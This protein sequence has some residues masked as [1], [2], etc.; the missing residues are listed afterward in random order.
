MK[1]YLT[2]QNRVTTDF[3]LLEANEKYI[4]KS[5]GKVGKS[6]I[7]KS[8]SNAGS[9]DN[10]IE[11]IKKET[12]EL[13][14]K[15]FSISQLPQDLTSSDIVFDKAKWHINDEFPKDLD[16]YQSYIHT[17]LYV[18][19]LLD[20]DLYDKDFKSENQQA[21]DSI[22]KRQTTPVKFYAQQLDGVFDADGLTQEAIKFT[23]KYFNFEKG[24]Y[25]QDY[26]TLL[27]PQDQQPSMFHFADTWSNYNKLKTIIDKRFMEWKQTA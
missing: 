8:T 27:D 2:K 21:I 5:A 12:Q 23:T 10:A 18:C 26:L 15:G 17:G 20:T 6:G 24:Q 11:E 7:F 16:H 3:V 4:Y 13:T 9:A 25:I 14:E 22:L 1:I 19:W